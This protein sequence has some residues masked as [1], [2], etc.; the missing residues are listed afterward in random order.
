[1]FDE[2]EL[3]RVPGR[4]HSLNFGRIHPVRASIRLIRFVP[5]YLSVWSFGTR[6]TFPYIGNFIILTDFNSMIFQRG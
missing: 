2:G 5:A 6:L 1:M 4:M 3:L